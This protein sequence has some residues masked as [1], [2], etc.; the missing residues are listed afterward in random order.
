MLDVGCHSAI[1][2]IEVYPLHPK[3]IQLFSDLFITVGH[4]VL[5]CGQ[6][7]EKLLLAG[8]LAF[9]SRHIVIEALYEVFVLLDGVR[10]AS[11]HPL[12]HVVAEVGPAVN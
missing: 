9:G 1:V 3:I 10:M 11:Q 4:C 2:C 5:N 12:T 7:V 8:Q 6:I